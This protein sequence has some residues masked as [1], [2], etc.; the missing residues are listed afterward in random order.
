MFGIQVFDDDQRDVINF[1]HPVYILD[2][3]HISTWSSGQKNYSFEHDLF[4]LGWASTFGESFDDASLD[5]YIENNS[6]LR[7]KSGGY[8]FGIFVFLRAI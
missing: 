1:I 2:F 6:S 5:V 7:W 3:F 4:V 8:S